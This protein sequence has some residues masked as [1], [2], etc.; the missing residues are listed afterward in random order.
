MQQNHKKRVAKA[1]SKSITIPPGSMRRFYEESD[2]TDNDD[3]EDWE[4]NDGD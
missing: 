3:D 1:Q 4:P 2:Q